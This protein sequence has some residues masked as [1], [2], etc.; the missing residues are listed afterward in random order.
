MASIAC[1]EIVVK[2]DRHITA[3]VDDIVFLRKSVVKRKTSSLTFTYIYSKGNNFVDKKMHSILESS[4]DQR[5]YVGSPTTSRPL[6][7]HTQ[8]T[9]AF[10]ILSSFYSTG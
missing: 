2:P 4:R 6:I 7:P 8:F 3:V 9:F 10:E 5:Y 1:E